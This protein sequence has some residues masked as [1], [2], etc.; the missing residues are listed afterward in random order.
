MNMKTLQKLQG[1]IH[2]TEHRLLN[3]IKLVKVN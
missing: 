1:S 2:N 3:N